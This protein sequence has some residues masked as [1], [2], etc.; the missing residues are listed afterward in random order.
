MNT[1]LPEQP[2]SGPLT[3]DTVTELYRSSAPWFAGKPEL[4]VD[5]SG[6]TRI[7]SAGLALMVEWLRQARDTKCALRFRNL[8]EQVLTLVRINGLQDVIRNHDA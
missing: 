7:D 2:V 4:V 5:C 8:P 6:V 3:F 1:G